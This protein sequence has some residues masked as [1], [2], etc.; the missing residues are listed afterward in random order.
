MHSARLPPVAP[1]IHMTDP[2]GGDL[3]LLKARQARLRQ[4]MN[5]QQL[6]AM[7]IRDG[8]NILYACGA[9]NM[10]VFNTRTPARYLLLFASGPCILFDY[11]GCAHLS[12]GLATI[13]QVLEAEGLDH[14]SSGGDPVA[15]GRRM[16]QTVAALVR[17]H[18]GRPAELGV[19]AL[20]LAAVDALRDQGFVLRDANAAID[21]SKAIKLPAELVVMQE[22]MR[23]VD[24]AVLSMREELRPGITENELW[25][26]Y[27]QP[28]L[29]SGGQYVVTRLLQSGPRTYPYFQECGERVIQSGDLVC[30]D[31]D[32][33]G[34]R[35]YA[36]DF[37]RTFLCGE[38]APSAGQQ[39]LYAL[40]HAQL[41]HNAALLQCG[42]SFE[43]IAVKAW[44]IPPAYRHS[45]YYAIGHGLGMSGD[46]PNIPHAQP[47][48]PYPLQG[49]LEAGMVVC[50]ESY[51]GSAEHRQGVKLENQYLITEEGPE[52]MSGFELDARL[53]TAGGL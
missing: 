53:R 11:F 41:E 6:P 19:D 49:G 15:S 10:T 2:T 24:Q 3:A 51:V 36:V 12:A 23:R 44:P 29:A 52:L 14:I 5:E 1:P 46:F 25:S 9:Q 50:I 38:G 45:R 34:Y 20:P 40:A 43:E 42:R 18:G 27:L 33:I 26:R 7:L 48:E 39:Q 16:A 28:M 47:G 30:L 35:G 37:S 13:N 17:E 22:A 4:V 32:A 21:R 8:I 31:T